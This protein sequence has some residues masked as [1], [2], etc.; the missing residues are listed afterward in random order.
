VRIESSG[1]LFENFLP[2]GP[3]YS[4]KKRLWAASSEYGP[5]ATAESV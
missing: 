5:A 3:E 2:F 4:R 1:L